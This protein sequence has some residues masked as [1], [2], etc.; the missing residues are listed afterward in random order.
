MIKVLQ[1]EEK[2]NYLKMLQI[3]AGTPHCHELNNIYAGRGE[4]L[5]IYEQFHSNT[6]YNIVLVVSIAH[7]L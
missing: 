1:K 4:I 6:I 3:T 5:K 2:I 7:N